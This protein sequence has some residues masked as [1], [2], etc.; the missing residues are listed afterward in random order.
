MI[1]RNAMITLLVFWRIAGDIIAFSNSNAPW[2]VGV[3]NN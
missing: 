3:L 1:A 2:S